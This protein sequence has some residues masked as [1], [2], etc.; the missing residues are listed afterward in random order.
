MT[1]STK[2]YKIEA[3]IVISLSSTMQKTECCNDGINEINF[4]SV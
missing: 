4:K 2:S 3:K 1:M